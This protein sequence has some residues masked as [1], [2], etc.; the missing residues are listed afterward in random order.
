MCRAMSCI[1]SLPLN[2]ISESG[3]TV[4]AI[5]LLIRKK[6]LLGMLAAS[7]LAIFLLLLLH[8]GEQRTSLKSFSQADSLI[9]EE[10]NR[11]RVGPDRVRT[12]EYP[13]TEDFTRKR[14]VVSLP[15]DVSQT[16]LHAELN[17]SLGSY[18]VQTIGHVNVPQRETRVLILFDN[19]I[20]R[21]V[22]F[23]TETRRTS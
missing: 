20:I 18:R 5:P 10:L 21:T 13:V 17:R 6:I 2:H 3:M 4:T 7:C 14:Y 22:E 12:F 15:P 9:I 16:H 11:F 8:P 23:R 1:T 19:K